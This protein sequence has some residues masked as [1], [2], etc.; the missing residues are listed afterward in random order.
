[1][2]PGNVNFVGD[3]GRQNSRGAENEAGEFCEDEGHYVQMTDNNGDQPE[4]ETPEF[5][6]LGHCIRFRSVL[7]TAICI[8]LMTCFSLLICLSQPGLAPAKSVTDTAWSNPSAS[9]FPVPYT[10]K[11]GGSPSVA[12]NYLSSE[13]TAFHF[14]P[15]RNWMN[16]PNGPMFYKGYYHIFYQYNP[17]AAVWGNITWAHSVSKD[18]VH[19]HPLNL[20]LVPDHWYDAEGVWSGSATVLPD[21][22][23]VILYTGS[24]NESVQL[25][26]MAVPEDLSDPLLRKWVKVP[27]NPMLVPPPSIGY[28]DFRDPTTA[29]LES[30]GLW[31][32]SIGAKEGTTG[33]AL[34][35]KTSDFLDW[36][37]QNKF[38]H[39]V[40][41]TG[42]W[43]CVDFYPVSLTGKTG[44]DTS[45]V[46]VNQLVKYVLKAS[47]DD[48][49]HDYYTVGVYSTDFLPDD[50][51]K[52]IGLGLRYDYGK[53][54]AS[55][56]FYDPVQERRILWGWVNESDS[57]LDDIKKGWASVQTIPRTL[58]LDNHTGSN[59]L[60]WPIHE[61]ESL[62]GD[63]VVKQDIL[64]DGG[65]MVKVDGASG[66][67]LDIEVTF[68]YPDVHKLDVL[69]EQK[70]YVCSQGGAA[71]R[72]VFGPFGLLVL[73][74]NNLVEQ[75]AVYFYLTLRPNGKWV[76]T[77]CS[78]QSRSSLA[79][80]IDRT[81]YG[82]TID[83]PPTDNFLSLRLIV[84]HSIVETFVQQ[85][86]ACITSRVYPTIAIDRDA[87]VFLFNNGNE[88][89]TM[90]T[91]QVWQ[92]SST[93]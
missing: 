23:P 75:T 77:V 71:E 22:K 25:Q 34:V 79:K 45:K 89:I 74:A 38:L 11:G 67:Q 15:E 37:L 88:S 49:K 47:L 70:E 40:A 18:L 56:T 54:Y 68:K 36:T 17:D 78:D 35:Y 19:W 85:G 33:L 29:W 30:D 27:Q 3:I 55:K 21:G 60:Q 84:D 31:R 91:L 20:A 63:K 26:N 44:L 50:P 12:D 7:L 86:I 43:E 66:S 92:M 1:M 59:L 10:T 80:G 46:Q 65:A 6:S 58:V 81:V 73:A 69:P 24:S 8:A 48:N 64:L 76:T 39:K 83:K 9:E 62:R 52:D 90:Q 72:G 57:E 2:A 51:T 4:F 87:H 13:R 61:L 14:Q 5:K 53:F 41:G 32:I 42:M 16:D 82:I 28:T 93:Y